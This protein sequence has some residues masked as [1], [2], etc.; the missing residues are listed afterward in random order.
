MRTRSA[1]YRR[2][3]NRKSTIPF[4]DY[5]RNFKIEQVI[6][7]I[8][9]SNKAERFMY[10]RVG[11]KIVVRNKRRFSFSEYSQKMALL[12]KYANIVINMGNLST[13]EYETKH[14]AFE[15]SIWEHCLPAGKHKIVAVGEKAYAIRPFVSKFRI[16]FCPVA[17]GISD[18]EWINLKLGISHS[19]DEALN[20]LVCTY[21]ALNYLDSSA[22]E[23][24]KAHLENVKVL[25]RRKAETKQTIHAAIE[26]LRKQ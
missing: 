26:K 1:S 16:G 18:L 8:K 3:T 17:S 15:E 10:V 20:N 13:E 19:F 25:F 9:G 23:M 2:D 24:V 6:R 5:C 4:P 14:Y 11:G 22:A 12:L 7:K 21:P